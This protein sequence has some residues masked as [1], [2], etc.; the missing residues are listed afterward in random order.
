MKILMIDSDDLV[1][2][3][4]SLAFQVRW[5]ELEFVCANLGR[6]G[7]EMAFTED[8]DIV[9]LEVGLRDI[10]GLEVLRRI[11]SFSS[12]PVI[13]LS[14]HH[15]ETIMTTALDLGADDYVMKPFRLAELEARIESKLRRYTHRQQSE[16]RP[17]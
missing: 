8:P 17:R 1:V 16:N 6:K 9:I 13:V 10:R 12:V 15:E 11:R 2:E 7:I 3:S 5:P 4:L 14:V